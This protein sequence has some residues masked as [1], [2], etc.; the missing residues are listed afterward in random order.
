MS[1]IAEFGFQIAEFG[2][3]VHPSRRDHTETLGRQIDE[4]SADTRLSLLHWLSGYS[5][6]AVQLAIDHVGAML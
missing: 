1:M 6:A 2:F 3:Q 4:M 5:P